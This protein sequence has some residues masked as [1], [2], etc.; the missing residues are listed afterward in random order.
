MK[1]G[2]KKIDPR[3]YL[4]LLSHGRFFY[5]F[6]PETVFLFHERFSAKSE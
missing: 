5:E 4:G 6:M 3:T 1:K 2:L